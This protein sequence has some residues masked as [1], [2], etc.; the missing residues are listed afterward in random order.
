MS[1]N[2]LKIKKSSTAMAIFQSRQCLFQSSRFV[3]KK[4]RAVLFL[5]P[6]FRYRSYPYT[7]FGTQSVLIFIFFPT[8]AQA[9][10]VW[11]F[12]IAHNT[13]Q[14]H[15]LLCFCFRYFAIAHTPTQT[16]ARKACLFLYSFPH[17]RRRKLG[18]ISLSLIPLHKLRHAKRAYFYIRFS[19]CAKH[20]LNGYKKL[21]AHNVCTQRSLWSEWRDLNSRPYGPEP[22]ALPNCATPR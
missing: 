14:R 1:K 5:F 3:D 13:T 4:T 2:L 16:S 19:R 9:Q 10:V 20:S 15:G 21:S 11:Y 6:V 8:Y 7:N 22:Y 17:M 12:A 18:G